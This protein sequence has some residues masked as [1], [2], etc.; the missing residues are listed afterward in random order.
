MGE[1]AGKNLFVG[2]TCQLCSDT[3]FSEVVKTTTFDSL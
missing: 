1:P 2:A 3:A